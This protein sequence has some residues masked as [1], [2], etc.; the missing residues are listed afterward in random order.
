MNE[1]QKEAFHDLILFLKGLVCEIDTAQYVKEY[2]IR[3]LNRIW[4]EIEASEV[5][6]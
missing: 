2:F 4:E 5:G 6:T 1:K 3:E